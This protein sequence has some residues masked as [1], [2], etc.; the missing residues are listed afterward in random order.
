IV[1]NP[2]YVT[3]HDK[4]QMHTNVTDFEPHTALFVTGDDPL[5]FYSAIAD[6]ALKR[7]VPGGLLFFEIN[8][9]FGPGT[10]QLLLDR[11]FVNVEVKKD[12]NGKDRMI[13]AEL[14]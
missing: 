8:E 11:N 2:P 4:T 1:S 7:L 13:R 10:A 14:K 12:M 9:N 6:F 5:L 3:P